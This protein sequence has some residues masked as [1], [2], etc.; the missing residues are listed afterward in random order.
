MER[1]EE[2]E[3]MRAQMAILNDKLSRE[4]IV[5]D[6]LFSMVVKTNKGVI[7]RFSIVEYTC[8]AFVIIWSL[9]FLPVFGLSKLFIAGTI[10]LM[11]FCAAATAKIN[12][13]VRTTDFTA[14]NM[15]EAAKEFK[16]LKKSYKTWLYIGVPL[17]IS[18]AAWFFAEIMKNLPDRRLAIG[19]VIGGCVGG[20]VGGIIGLSM[21]RRVIKACDEVIAQIEN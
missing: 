16:K 7:N 13:K 1:N 21:N 19:M 20:L 15:L 11:L 2:L 5:N 17:G 8:C 6:K 4:A 3:E 9:L 14:S 10:I 18:W 12:W